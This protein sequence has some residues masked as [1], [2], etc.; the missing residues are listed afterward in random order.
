[1]EYTSQREVMGPERRSRLKIGS[2]Y[3]EEFVGTLYSNFIT[4]PMVRDCSLTSIGRPNPI[5]NWKWKEY[6]KL[7]VLKFAVGNW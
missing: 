6:M 1:M 5:I 7:H 3:A 2:R 4:V